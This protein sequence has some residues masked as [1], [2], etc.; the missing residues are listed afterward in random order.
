[1]SKLE[2]AL[3]SVT[4]IEITL[5]AAQHALME[6]A[7]YLRKNHPVES[8]A[9]LVD[10]ERRGLIRRESPIKLSKVDALVGYLSRE[11]APL[12]F[13]QAVWKRLMSARMTLVEIITANEG[14]AEETIERPVLSGW[15]VGRLAAAQPPGLATMSEANHLVAAVFRAGR[16]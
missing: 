9:L 6:A 12:D 10:W 7:A 8:D 2:D 15:F 16:T 13:D 3:G 11:Q 4:Q 1:M 14:K 5:R